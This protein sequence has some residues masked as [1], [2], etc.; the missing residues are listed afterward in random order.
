MAGG[1][2]HKPPGT[3]GVAGLVKDLQAQIAAI[4]SGAGIR[5]SVIRNKD[6][7]LQ[8]ESGQRVG[9]FGTF[10]RR[11]FAAIGEPDSAETFRG[12]QFVDPATGEPV[13]LAGVGADDLAA[14]DI[15][16]PDSLEGLAAFRAFAD[17]IKLWGNAIQFVSP[18]TQFYSLPTTGSAANL[19]L[20]APTPRLMLVTSS[21]KYKED[22]ADAVVDPSDVLAL[23]G[24]TWVDRAGMER[25][26]E[27][28]I[29]RN[30]GFIAEELDDLPSLRQ[31]VDYKD[32]EPDA[33]QYDRLSV[34]LLA[35][36]KWL[37]ARADRIEAENTE[38][39]KQVADLVARVTRLEG[40]S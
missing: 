39:R 40:G 34:A 17:V 19:R 22:I 8:N 20:D 7:Q 12:S 6:L 35:A 4:R 36:L 33:I 29:G 18:E 38:L 14:V 30:I 11:H 23:A 21:R 13:L 9:Q 3:E 15:G 5:S 28:D 1:Y 25:A 26:D 31:F 27:G 10:T 24:R 2:Q 32:G 16:S 37:A